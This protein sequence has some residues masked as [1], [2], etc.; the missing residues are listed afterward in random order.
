MSNSDVNKI[1]GTNNCDN[2]YKNDSTVTKNKD[3]I[4]YKEKEEILSVSGA[5]I[6]TICEE[7][8]VIEVDK[9]KAPS[10][11][12]ND[13]VLDMNDIIYQKLSDTESKWLNRQGTLIKNFLKQ[14]LKR[15][16]HIQRLL[17]KDD[18]MKMWA[19]FSFGGGRGS[20][21]G[22]GGVIGVDYHSRNSFIKLVM[23]IV[24]VMLFTT[25]AWLMFVFMVTFRKLRILENRRLHFESRQH[26][27]N[28]KDMLPKKGSTTSVVGPIRHPNLLLLG[29]GV[30]GV[31]TLM[32]CVHSARKP[33]YN[34]G[35]LVFSVIF[36]SLMASIITCRYRTVILIYAF[37]S[38]S[39]I[40]LVCVLLSYTSF[41]FTS[42]WLYFVVLSV[43]FSVIVM[44]IVISMVLADVY[45]KAVHILLLCMTV[46]IQSMG[47]VMEL[48]MILGNKSIEIDETDYILAAFMIYTSVM[49]MF[50][51]IA[52][53]LGM[54]DDDG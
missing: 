20:G 11:V 50:M 12:T 54:T 34:Y 13:I 4:Q 1:H 45:L 10:I 8:S 53:I 6:S 28:A 41:D 27:S 5:K 29:G 24:L 9:D 3:F 39:I 40:V 14:G 15:P 18:K 26:G 37:I 43:G 52:Q 42:F 30:L 44:S 17:N 49:K 46:G 19:Q 35:V 36:T 25:A 21:F 38:T 23:Q 22:E 48:Q 51:N 16:Q 7:D 47:L 2:E 32:L 33:P 31:Y